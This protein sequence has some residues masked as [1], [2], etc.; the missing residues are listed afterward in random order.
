MFNFSTECI[1][2]GLFLASLSLFDMLIMQ[3]KEDTFWNETSAFFAQHCH[4]DARRSQ[5]RFEKCQAS[6]FPKPFVACI[7]ECH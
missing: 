3:I 6:F 1:N 4:Q 7:I 2:Q 5:N